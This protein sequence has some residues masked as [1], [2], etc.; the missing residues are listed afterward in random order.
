[1]NIETTKSYKYDVKKL[2]TESDE[3][4]C[5]KMFF[6]DCRHDKVYGSQKA[7]FTI[8]NFEIFKVIEKKPNKTLNENR[9]NLML[10]HGTKEEIVSK[11]LENGFKNSKEGWYGKVCFF[12]LQHTYLKTSI[13]NTYC[14]LLKNYK[15]II[16]S[17]KL[18]I[19]N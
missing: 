19:L 8:E 17:K 9:N 4:K 3:F 12:L 15:I 13:V 16:Q 11:I 2:P 14:L 18:K 5:V 6:D 1:M 7:P 10:F